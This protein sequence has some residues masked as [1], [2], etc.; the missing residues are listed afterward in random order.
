MSRACLTIDL[1]ALAHNYAVVRAQAGGALVT[2]VIKADGYGLGAASIARRLW[3]EGARGF[4]VA[5]LDEGEALREALDSLPAD[6]L[7]LDGFQPGEEARLGAAGL[8]PVLNTLDQVRAY[9]GPGAV[10]HFDTGMNRIGLSV[11]EAAAVIGLGVPVALVMSHLG[12]AADPDHPRNGRQLARFESVRR[13]FPAAQAS[14][15]ASA[16]IWLGEDYRFDQVRPGIGLF[17]GG[18]REVPDPALKAVARLE[19]PV[20]QLRDIAAGDHV[21]Y[22]DMF[23]ASADMRIAL[24]AAGYADGLLRRGAGRTWA[25]MNGARLPI[26]AVTMDLIAIDITGQ[27]DPRPGELAE[28]LGPHALLDDLASAVG[29]APHE[30]LTRLSSR[31]RRVYA[32]QSAVLL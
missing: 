9:R 4:F 18:P 27:P 30:C 31:A 21:G 6:I 8:T 13:L 25:W 17:G 5:R 2:P 23:T 26:L 24:V 12:N 28:L 11:D 10:L 22:G 19:A 20:L 15:A 14:L 7:V 16:G 3:R 29:T 32:E 1:D